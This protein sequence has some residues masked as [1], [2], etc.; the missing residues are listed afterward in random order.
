MRRFIA[1]RA[2]L[3]VSL[4]PLSAGATSDPVTVEPPKV[5]K[6]CRASVDTGTILKKKTCRTA[7]EWAEIDQQRAKDADAFA[8]AKSS[9]SVGQRDN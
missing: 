3:V 8:R 7:E 2:S 6:I 5:K 9:G 1:Y 4:L